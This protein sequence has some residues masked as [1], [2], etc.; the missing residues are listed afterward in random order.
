MTSFIYEH[1]MPFAFIHRQ[2][3]MLG[4]LKGYLKKKKTQYDQ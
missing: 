1:V 4:T 3:Y 2:I